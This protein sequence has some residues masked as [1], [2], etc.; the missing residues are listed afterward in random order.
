MYSKKIPIS[1]GD[2]EFFQP[3]PNK[4]M[5]I[6]FCSLARHTSKMGPSSVTNHQSIAISINSAAA[7]EKIDPGLIII[8]PD[9]STGQKPLNFGLFVTLAT[10]SYIQ[11]ASQPAS[12]AAWLHAA[13][14]SNYCTARW[15]IDCLRHGRIIAR[16]DR[17]MHPDK[18]V[19]LRNG[20]P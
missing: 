7:S 16:S 19:S 14:A 9:I 15:T 10:R 1:F 5:I 18:T 8:F 6:I 13:T 4:E 3:R 11:P 12:P 20:I 2:F 17:R